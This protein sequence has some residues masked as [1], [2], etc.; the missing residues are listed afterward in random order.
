M[1]EKVLN[2]YAGI[3]GNRKLW[4]DVDVTAVEWDEKI[5]NIYA[6][7][8][9]DD[10]VIVADAHQFLEDNYNDG[11]DFIWSSPPC[12]THSRLHHN[13]AVKHEGRP[14][15]G[16]YPDMSLYQEIILLDKSF[17]GDWIVE[18]VIPYY[19][20]LIEPQIVNRHAFWSNYQIPD[21]TISGHYILEGVTSKLEKSVGISIQEYDLPSD[22]YDKRQ[23]LRNCVHPELGKHVFDS[24]DCLNDPTEW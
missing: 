1:T 11:Y 4:Q 5:A 7:K 19:D 14:D 24:R 3:G 21:V 22:K 12:Q 13:L 8:Y 16:R 9:P 17:S 18:N 6:D 15:T 2:L 23:V 10:N 20:F